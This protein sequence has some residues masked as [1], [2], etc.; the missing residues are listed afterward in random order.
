M[1]KENDE[2]SINDSHSVYTE[3]KW[4]KEDGNKCTVDGYV[5]RGKEPFNIALDGLKE[6]M[7]KGTNNEIQTIKYKALDTRKKGTGLEID[8]EVV[9]NKARGVAL[10]KLY[11]PSSKDEYVV[12][13]SKS[14]KS[15][16]K[17]VI[18][19]AEKVIKPLMN[20]FLSEELDNDDLKESNST[21]EKPLSV[22]EK[23][24]VF[25]C[26]VCDKCFSS[27]GGLKGHVTKIHTK[28]TKNKA[29]KR[30]AL[31]EAKHVVED[32]LNEIIEISDEEDIEEVTLEETA[33]KKDL[34]KRYVNECDI[35]GY[36]VLANRKYVS[37][38]MIKKHKETCMERTCNLCDFI[39][40]DKQQLKRHRRDEH[41][42]IT[43]STSPPLKKKKNQAGSKDVEEPMNMGKESDNEEDEIVN[44]SFKLEDM[45]VDEPETDSDKGIEYERSKIMDE[46]IKQK[47][48]QNSKN[49]MKEEIKR[50]QND[51]KKQKEK[52]KEIQRIQKEKKQNKQKIKDLKRKQKKKSLPKKKVSKA[53]KSYNIPNIKD[54]PNNCKHLVKQ[55]D[56][57]YVVPGDGCCGPNCGAAFLF[58]DEVFGPKLR[59][60]MNFFFANHWYDR[61]Q[62]LTQCSPGHPF[63]RKVKGEN[64][65]FTDPVELIKYFKTSEDAALYM[66]SDSEDFAILADMYQINIKV[67]TTK[68]LNDEHPTVNWIYPDRKMV[69]FAELENVKL[70]DMVV[71]HEED[72]HFNLVIAGDSD[73]AMHGSLSYRFN[74]GPVVEKESKVS[75]DS[76]EDLVMNKDDT[77]EKDNMDN[78]KKQLKSCEQSKRYLEAEYIKC[79]KALRNTTEE[80]VKLKIEIKDLK[81]I[82]KLS[83]QIEDMDSEESLGSK[84]T[85]K[86]EEILLKMK[87]SGSRRK[88]PQVEATP[89]K[90]VRTA[91][92][93][94]KMIIKEDE[95][96][97]NECYFQGTSKSELS[98]HF[99]LKHTTDQKEEENVI[100]CK[101]C[102][103]KFSTKWSL[104][105][106]RKAKH[107]NTV[108]FCRNKLEG[109]CDFADEKCWWNHAE[110]STDNIQCF[111]CNHVFETKTQM[112]IHRKNEHKEIV[113]CCS[114]F[115]QGTCRFR[116]D[117]CWFLHEL[118]GF[119][120]A[121]EFDRT[122]KKQEQVFRKVLKPTKPP[123]KN[124]EEEKKTE[125]V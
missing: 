49:E 99:N 76:F 62:H 25:N 87:D 6:K 20:R 111:I 97:C 107:I 125:E 75:E 110:K 112:M 105:N 71:L 45:D 15:D 27:A 120:E 88:S 26:D 33:V 89:A 121:K 116:N 66:W 19:L 37:L 28:N 57:I 5:F 44:L 21:K 8:V 113:K 42:F 77:T 40:K 67:I 95:F 94:R 86:E 79:E 124:Q 3:K 118:E 90:P 115:Q 11:G 50:K 103:D 22:E 47:E 117:S 55:S 98:K 39:P 101:T 59:K 82:V 38:Q 109:K 72:S 41:G 61:Y 58:K 9:D 1:S 81:E 31:E 106:H 51:L 91:K 13:V 70:D 56:V 102:G 63:V 74:I 24:K 104:M 46:K 65:S 43:G 34:E 12:T 16:L 64:I 78:L 123:S 92:A 68:G 93:I 122:S 30:K 52:E 80:N 2:T 73:L 23:V 7:K 17:Y 35:C 83:K 32:I 60:A 10:L 29:N 108:A 18:I 84:E 53:P 54:V 100:T 114:Q 85:F 69:E 48:Q 96:N 4:G 119:T 14:R 36:E